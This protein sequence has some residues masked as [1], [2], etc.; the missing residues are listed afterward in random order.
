LIFALD[1]EL[2]V[3]IFSPKKLITVYKC[4]QDLPFGIL[5]K[6]Q[7]ARVFYSGEIDSETVFVLYDNLM[8]MLINHKEE[9]VK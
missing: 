3:R 1:S 9:D 7:Q 6:L 5:P 2:E 4:Q 8:Y